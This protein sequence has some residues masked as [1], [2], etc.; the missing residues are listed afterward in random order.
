MPESFG[1]SFEARALRL[2]IQRVIGVGTV[3]DP[4]QQYQSGVAGEFAFFQDCFERA[5]LA[6]MAKLDVLDVVGNGV[7]ALRLRHHLFSG[8]EHELGVL[9]DEL[10]DEPWAGDAIHLDLFAGDPFHAEFSFAVQLSERTRIPPS[11]G[12][13]T[14]SRSGGT[15][16]VV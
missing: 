5:F 2:L 6:V 11:A 12:E 7:E 10:L 4:P 9:I 8:H 15:S 16:T 3:D 14:Y 1:D 13:I